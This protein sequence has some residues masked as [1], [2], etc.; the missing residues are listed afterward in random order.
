MSV[1]KTGHSEYKE[2]IAKITEE[3]LF[4]RWIIPFKKNSKFKLQYMVKYEKEQRSK[5]EKSTNGANFL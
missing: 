3:E 1:K 4:R 2:R 5:S